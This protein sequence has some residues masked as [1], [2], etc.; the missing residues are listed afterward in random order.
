MVDYKK[1]SDIYKKICCEMASQD[2]RKELF[3]AFTHLGGMS[4]E[5]FLS[6]L[7]GIIEDPSEE[8]VRI[9]LQRMEDI[10]VYDM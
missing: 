4:T 7:L 5:W 2:E 9:F 10:L 6:N 8:E 1:L 3:Y